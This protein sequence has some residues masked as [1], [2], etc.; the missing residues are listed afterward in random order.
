MAKPALTNK[1]FKN[2]GIKP[3][4]I[5]NCLSQYGCQKRGK[6]KNQ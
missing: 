1:P 5:Q 3:L 4:K 6:D 2:I